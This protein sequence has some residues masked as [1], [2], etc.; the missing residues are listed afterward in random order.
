MRALD[1][2][3]GDTLHTDPEHP[4]GSLKGKTNLHGGLRKF[5]EDLNHLYRREPA[6][7]EV[8]FEPS[9]FEWIDCNDHEASVISLIRRARNPDDCAD[10][11]HNGDGTPDLVK[12]R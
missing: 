7:Y 4:Y 1:D 2:I 3:K 5:V 8:D 6:L 12:Y 9:G 10:Q 11:D